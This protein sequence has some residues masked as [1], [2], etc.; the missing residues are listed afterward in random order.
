MSLQHRL[1]TVLAAVAMLASLTSTALA[2]NECYFKVKKKTGYWY[3]HARDDEGL[4]VKCDPDYYPVACMVKFS[5][6]DDRNKFWI[7]EMYPK[8][9]DGY[10]GC[11]VRV[12]TKHYEGNDK[13]FY[14]YASCVPYD[15]VHDYPSH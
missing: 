10:W 2:A 13:Q 11:Y 6:K 3:E 14:G 9:D 12:G 8:E 7:H 15:C 1:L 5:D 4:F